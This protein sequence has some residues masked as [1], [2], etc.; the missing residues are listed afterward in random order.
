MPVTEAWLINGI[1][2]VGKSTVAQRLA[3]SLPRAAHVEGDRLHELILS[4]RVLPGQAPH[5]ESDAQ[6]HL[7]VRNQCLLAQ[8]L[9]R[10]G[11]VPILDYVVVNRRRV[12]EYLSQ[13][14]G[15]TL[16]LVTLAPGAE[17]ALARDRSRPEKTVAAAWT[18]LE[19][20]IRRELTGV[21][22]WVDNKAL[23]VEETV[24]YLLHA[25]ESARVD[26]P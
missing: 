17:V 1:P 20:V 10:D 4:G 14:P 23:S 5:E 16:Q 13:L 18:H 2:G 6:I 12:E 7:C 11:F 26:A 8:S 25:Q 19:E 21:G 9:A 24:A 3:R 15:L 22:L